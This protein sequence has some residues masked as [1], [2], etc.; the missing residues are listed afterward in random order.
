MSRQKNLAK[1]AAAL[2]I[3]RQA[4]EEGWKEEE[5]PMMDRPMSHANEPILRQALASCREAER[6]CALTLRAIANIEC[7]D[8]RVRNWD[9]VRAA[10]LARSAVER[11]RARIERSLTAL[12]ALG[13]KL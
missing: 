2:K 12:E 5:S 11:T 4:V 7:I 9:A 1:R 13:R 3:S 8:G 10:Q 6:Q